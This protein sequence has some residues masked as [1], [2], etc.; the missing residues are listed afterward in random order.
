VTEG[1]SALSTTSYAILGQLAWGEATTY[2]LVKAMRRNLRYIWPRAESRIYEE[3]KRLVTEGL[4]T[5]SAGSTGRRRRT[6]YSITPQGRTALRAWLAAKA[7]TIS[8]EHEPLLRILLGR[9]GTPQDLL[10]AVEAVRE[11]AEAMLSIGRPLASEYINRTHPQQHE[12]HLRALSF[13]YLFNWALLNREW[14]E[15]AHNEIARWT[16]TA[17]DAQKHRRALRRIRDTIKREETDSRLS[18]VG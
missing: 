16:D 7:G 15:R 13:D 6:V 4:A 1:N 9:E 10:T 11:H 2:E 12:V 18:R 5:V 17:P 3:A 8:L 14:A